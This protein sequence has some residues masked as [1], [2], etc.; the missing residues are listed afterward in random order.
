[1][2]WDPAQ[3]LKYADH[4]LRPAID[5]LKRVDL[6]CRGDVYDLGAGAGNVTRLIKARATA[7]AIDWQHADLDAWQPPRPAQL[8]YSNAAL[9]WLAGHERLF[10]ALLAG[11]APGGVLAVQMPRNFE[12]PSH[13][14]I[15]RGGAGRALARAARA[16]PAAGSGSRPRCLLR[17]ARAQDRGAR[18]L[19]DRVFTGARG[20][21][22]GQGMDQGNLA[23]AAAGRTRGAGA[24]PAS[25]P[26]TRR[27]SLGGIC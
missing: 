14:A 25:R 12:A 13:T 18:H 27:W 26:T 24:Q 22:P 2:S 16:R 11:L 3:Y 5:L 19:G 20:R 17:P 1:M 7:P 6:E 21:R 23:Q 15:A 4:R 10:P 9:H 8:I